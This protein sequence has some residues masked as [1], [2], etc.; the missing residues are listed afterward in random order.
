[1]IDLGSTGTILGDRESRMNDRQERLFEIQEKLQALWSK[2]EFHELLDAD[3]TEMWQE[4]EALEQ[5]EQLYLRPG[6]RK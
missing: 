2:I 4:Y 5:V 3:T 1:M 6:V